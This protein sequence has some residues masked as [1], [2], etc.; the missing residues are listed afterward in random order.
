[1]N[2]RTSLYKQANLKKMVTADLNLDKRIEQA[3][4]ELDT[5]RQA[6]TPKAN[7]AVQFPELPTKERLKQLSG[8]RGM[9]DLEKVVVVTGFGEVGPYGNARTR[10][11]M[12][13]YGEFS[14][15]GC[16]ELAWMMTLI[17]VSTFYYLSDA[18]NAV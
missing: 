7:I 12:E 8:I 10:W 2:L 17:K 14:M 13:C 16:I 4:N 5:Q 3:T 18:T 15:E 9:V 11:E 1:M 6:V